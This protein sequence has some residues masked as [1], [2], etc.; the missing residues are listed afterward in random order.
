M[1]K[2]DA[3]IDAGVPA[4]VLPTVKPAPAVPVVVAYWNWVAPEVAKYEK[5]PP[6]SKL[7]CSPMVRLVKPT[8]P[9]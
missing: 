8:D 2:Y 6:V 9:L 1:V 3:G 4:T 7:S 5:L